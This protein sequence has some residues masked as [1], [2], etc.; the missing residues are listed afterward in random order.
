V[1][2]PKCPFT[3]CVQLF[4]VSWAMRQRKIRLTKKRKKEANSNTNDDVELLLKIG[5]VMLKY[6]VNCYPRNEVGM[7]LGKANERDKLVCRHVFINFGCDA[8]KIKTNKKLKR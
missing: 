6:W 3:V 5:L 4:T 1:L 2:C 8:A 7:V